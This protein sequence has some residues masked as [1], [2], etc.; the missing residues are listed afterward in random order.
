MMGNKHYIHVVKNNDGSWAAVRKHS[1]RTIFRSTNKFEALG[2]AISQAKR[3]G[4]TEVIVED[5]FGR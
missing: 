3:E 2:K 1:S 5:K 4:N